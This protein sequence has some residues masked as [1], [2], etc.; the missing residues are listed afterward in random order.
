MEKAI[1]EVK[2]LSKKFTLSHNRLPY[3]TFRDT[4]TDLVKKPFRMLKGQKQSKKEEFW[5]LKDIN[6]QIQKGE[7]IGLIGPNGSG[8]STLLKLLSQITAPTTG[9][10][11]LHG[12]V[13][14]LLEVGTGFHP[15]LTGRENIFLNG[16]ILGMTKKE[17]AKKFNEIAK[18]SGVEKFLDTPIKRYSSGMNV[19][20]AF[21][22]A[23]H[24]EPDILIVDEVLAVGDAEFQKKCLGKMGEVTREVG[25][26]VILVSHNMEAIKKLCTRCILLKEGRLEIFDET[27]K[28]VDAYLRGGQLA[29]QQP[30]RQR[31]D[32]DSKGRVTMTDIS[33][34]TT[35]GKTEIESGDALRFHI[36]Y[37][38]IFTKPIQ[39]VRMVIMVVNDDLQNIL[40]FDNEVS[41]QTL[42]EFSPNGEFSCETGPLDLS[43][44]RYFVNLNF[45]I[46]GASED[47]IL[48]AA[49]FEVKENLNRYAFQKS[50][51]YKI[52]SFIAP[53]KYAQKE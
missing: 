15:E 51:D 41:K 17:I 37:E 30:L 36:K 8:K 45:H 44:G 25:R 14:S 16:A 47:S 28:V 19:R 10:I 38:S 11:T 24:M 3:E 49:S 1:I 27:T 23:A 5:A 26:T 32:R 7:A 39:N 50:A 53:F 29:S 46:D 48:M 34:T 22:V 4:V 43:P 33:V 12:K 18:F 40:W 6:F 42:T 13:A 20:L 21:S 52:T 9:E 31:R 35:S 2:N